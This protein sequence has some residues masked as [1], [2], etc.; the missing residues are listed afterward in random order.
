M[1]AL[2]S[3]LLLLKEKEPITAHAW[4]HNKMEEAWIFELHYARLPSEDRFWATT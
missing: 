1:D 2:N 4:T 3:F